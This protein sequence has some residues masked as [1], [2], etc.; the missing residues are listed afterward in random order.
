VLP[1]LTVDYVSERE[2]RALRGGAG[3]LTNVNTPEELAAVGGRFE[4]C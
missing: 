2:L 3:S 1:L 4:E